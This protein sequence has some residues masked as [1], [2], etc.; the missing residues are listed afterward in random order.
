MTAEMRLAEHVA[1]LQFDRLSTET[2]AEVEKLLLDTLAAILSGVANA[3]CRAVVERLL[4]NACEGPSSV[5]GRAARTAPDRAAFANGIYAHW[6][7]WDDVHDDA[8]IHGSAV[9]FPVVMAAAEAA[10]DHLARD[11]VTAVVGAYDVAARVGQAMNATS[12]HGWMTTG[13]AA[14]IGAAAGAARLFGMDAAGILSAMGVAATG[15][16]LRRQPLAD[17]TDGKNA[18]CGMAAVNAINAAEL[19]RAGI[20]GA[21]NFFAGPFGISALHARGRSDLEPLLSD[22][23][24]RFAICEASLKPYPTCRSTHPS[25][26]M[27]LDLKSEDPGIGEKIESINL[28]VPMLPHALCGRPFEAGDNPR[29]S[30]QFSIPFTV[31][32]ALTNGE[33]TLQ[34]FAPDRV[35]EFADRRA[36]LIGSIV[37]APDANDLESRQVV[38]PMTGIFRLSDGRVVERSTDSIKGS[39]SRPMTRDEECYKLAAAAAGVLAA[40]EIGKLREAAARIQADGVPP[41]TDVLRRAGRR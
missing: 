28:V 37:V 33:I 31:A 1:G 40:E 21:P 35:L 2:R 34:D 17:R 38:V 22:L 3:E 9:I 19:A 12:F 29:V 25:I 13:A 11:F 16:G 4:D 23:G 27:A 5:A 15:G 7:E 14:A 6:C 32:L 26:D 20:I 41:V 18:L 36:D 8:G 24:S 10:G 30:A 39:L